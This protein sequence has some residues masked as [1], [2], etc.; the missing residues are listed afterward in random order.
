MRA[1]SRRR[2]AEGK[3]VALVPT[4]GFLHEGHLSLVSAAVA[5][6]A[7]PVA[8]VVSI[9][10]NPSQFAPTEDLATYPSDFAGDLRKLAATGVVAAIFCPR[11]FYVRGSA[12]RPSAAGASGDARLEKGLCGSS[13]PIFFRGVATVVAKLFNV[14]EPDVAVFGKKDYQQWRVICRMVRDLDFAIHIVGS[15]IVREA[16]GLAMSSRNVNLS[17][18]NREKALSISRSLMDARTAALNG[19]NH[20]QQIKDQIVQ[21]LTEAGGQADYVEI[22]E[23][24][25]LVPAERM[26]RPC[27][28]CVAAWFGK[29]SR[30]STE[31]QVQGRAPPST[32]RLRAG[33]GPWPASKARSKMERKAYLPCSASAPCLRRCGRPPELEGT[34]EV[35]PDDVVGEIL[36]R[37]PPADPASLVRA[38]L[39][40]KPWY[41]IVCGPSFRRRFMEF[42][43]VAPLLGFLCNTSNPNARFVPTSSFRPPNADDLIALHDCEGVVEE[44][45][46]WDWDCV[47]LDAR[48][49]LVLLYF[50]VGEDQDDLLVVWNPTTAERWEI[51]PVP[52]ICDCDRFEWY[53]TVLSASTANGH[54]DCHDNMPFVVVRVV[55]QSHNQRSF[56]LATLETS[57]IH[58]PPASK[59]ATVLMAME[60]GGG[61]GFARVDMDARLSL[62]SMEANPNGDMG[63]TQTRVIELEKLLPV[64]A[65]SIFCSFL[66]FAHAVGVFFVATYDDGLFSFNLKSGR[67]RKVYEE[68][69]DVFDYL[70]RVPCVVPYTGFCTP[71]CIFH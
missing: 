30:S 11:T 29:A 3:A 16:D 43:R 67:V 5:A 17:H 57:V 12:D 61:L 21:T 2:R 52:D 36:L 44:E 18:E 9:Y 60:D 8:V 24:E 45:V 63:W 20:S 58:L 31:L 27:V 70:G 26:D 34:M 41:R 55:T 40:C 35:L 65:D 46:V 64:D 38:A 49:G 39:V 6:S 59:C 51:F 28:I 37:F 62:W 50:V 54:L 23:Q 53:A 14:V 33:T 1:W 71:A 7:G 32:E 42:H 22:V 19:S 66:G 47:A 15:E 56:D 68:E 13:R 25:S 69:C 4:M 48:H 10:V